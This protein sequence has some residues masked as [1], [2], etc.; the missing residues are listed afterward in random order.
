MFR[1]D[2]Q[3][4]FLS[5]CLN[6]SIFGKVLAA[7]CARWLQ[8]QRSFLVGYE[9]LRGPDVTAVGPGCVCVGQ[10][11]LPRQKSSSS[12]PHGSCSE[13][14]DTILWCRTLLSAGEC[15][16]RALSTLTS[17]DCL[18]QPHLGSP[19]TPPLLFSSSGALAMFPRAVW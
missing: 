5:P 2:Q 6:P 3:C 19:P 11:H 16:F 9:R 13:G 17:L 1:Q 7:P 10:A 14:T 18:E 8:Q 4:H 12:H 15:F